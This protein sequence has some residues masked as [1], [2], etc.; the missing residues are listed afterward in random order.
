MSVYL[1]VNNS[2]GVVSN[3]IE[4]DG[5]TSLNIPDVTIIPVPEQPEG[6]WIG[7]QLVDDE[8]IAPPPPP[9]TDEV[10]SDTPPE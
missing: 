4:W 5:G 8:W 10:T 6:V 7:W 9:T 3:A 1:V 2:D